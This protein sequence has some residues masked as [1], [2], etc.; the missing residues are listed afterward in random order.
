MT[1]PKKMMRCGDETACL[2]AWAKA[3][4]LNYRTLW[5]RTRRWGMGCRVV[6]EPLDEK[7]SKAAKLRSAKARA[8]RYRVPPKSRR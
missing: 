2:Y 3:S 1:F 4:G 8:K 5:W 6:T 7:M